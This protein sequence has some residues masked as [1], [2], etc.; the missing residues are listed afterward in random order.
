MESVERRQVGVIVERRKLKSAWGDFSWHPSAVLP[1]V[2]ALSAW[3]VT[4][5]GDGWEQYYVGAA[6]LEM[7]R[8]ETET[9]K[10]NLES[11]EPAVYVFLR[12]TVEEPGIELFG[13]T[14]CPGEAHAHRD[15]GDDIVEPVAMPPP[16][17]DWVAAFVE[18]HHV[19]REFYKRK[20]QRFDPE[21]LARKR[22]GGTS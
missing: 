15:T 14:V 20:N 16:I 19:E 11:A 4:A 2:P 22:P 8:T 13:A 7:F 18:A 10:Y 1:G 5:K 12:H 6:T 17:R 21:T 9:L 3:T